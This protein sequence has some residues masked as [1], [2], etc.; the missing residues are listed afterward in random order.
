[1]ADAA[2]QHNATDSQVVLELIAYLNLACQRLSDHGD[3]IAAIDL[4]ATNKQQWLLYWAKMLEKVTASTSD[5]KR[6]KSSTEWSILVH[7]IKTQLSRLTIPELK[8]QFESDLQKKCDNTKKADLISQ[9]LD[10][11]LAM[12]RKKESEGL[13]ADESLSLLD[14]IMGAGDKVE[15]EGV[16]ATS[17]VALDAAMNFA[18]VL[19]KAP[20]GSYI[21]LQVGSDL[22]GAKAELVAAEATQA[23]WRSRAQGGCA[24][25]QHA[26]AA[27]FKVLEDKDGVRRVSP[28][29]YSAL[30]EAD[31]HIQMI[32][33]GRVTA[34]RHGAWAP[35]QSCHIGDVSIDENVWSLSVSPSIDM[36]KAGSPEFVPAWGVRPVDKSNT[37]VMQ[38]VEFEFKSAALGGNDI[39]LKRLALVPDPDMIDDGRDARVELTRPLLPSEVA[40][41]SARLQALASRGDRDKSDSTKRARSADRG[42][43]FDE[44]LSAAYITNMARHLLK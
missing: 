35:K 12:E 42:D 22:S 27:C 2:K 44:E 36:A 4:D 3:E 1:M 15:E 5:S 32:F 16:A 17:V 31:K 29:L 7:T 26:T 39:T 20:L 9:L 37:M 28:K 38:H 21:P 40:A 10:H 41:Q 6:P 43:E 18:A 33:V 23:L 11:K 34:C 30:R 14:S 24:A 25:D 13:A 8:K 19:R